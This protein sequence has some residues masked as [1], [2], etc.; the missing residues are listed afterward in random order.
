MAW[1]KKL[2]LSSREVFVEW[3]LMGLRFQEDFNLALCEELTGKKWQEWIYPSKLAS[4]EG[5]GLLKI[6]GNLLT[7]SPS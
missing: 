3:L 1:K 2:V 5:G 6:V 7:L 4:L